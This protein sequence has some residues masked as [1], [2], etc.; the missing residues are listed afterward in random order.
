[1]PDR[2]ATGSGVRRI[3]VKLLLQR[4]RKAEEDIKAGRCIPQ[5][6][7]FSRLRKK[8]NELKRSKGSP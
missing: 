6:Q 8:L 7:V 1:M 5:A 3:P 4:L 2:P